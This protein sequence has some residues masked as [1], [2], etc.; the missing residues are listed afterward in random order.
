MS[1]DEECEDDESGLGVNDDHLCPYAWAKPIHELN[2][3]IVVPPLDFVPHAA[4]HD[5]EGCACGDASEGDAYDAFMALRLDR[6]ISIV[7][8]RVSGRDQGTMDR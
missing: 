8:P 1:R 6:I 4:T 7:Y 2:C 5:D 3:K